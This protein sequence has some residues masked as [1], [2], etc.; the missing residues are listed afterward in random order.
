MPAENGLAGTAN[1]TNEKPITTM[2]TVNNKG[3]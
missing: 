1:S 3:T 2:W